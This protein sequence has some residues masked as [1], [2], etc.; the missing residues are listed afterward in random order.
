M[1]IK[2]ASIFTEQIQG[3]ISDDEYAEFQGELIVNPELGDIVKKSG[4]TRKVRMAA[5]GKSG[6][7]R[8]LLKLLDTE[9]EH[10]IKTIHAG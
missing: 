5:K 9:P 10:T 7:A 2:E 6:D 1:I 8:V 4:G 3:L